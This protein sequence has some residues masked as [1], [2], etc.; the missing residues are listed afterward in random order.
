MPHKTQITELDKVLVM[1]IRGRER[2]RRRR[3][4]W[5]NLSICDRAYRVST[6]NKAHRIHSRRIMENLTTNNST[7]I[8]G[9]SSP[10]NNM[11]QSSRSVAKVEAPTFTNTYL[12]SHLGHRV[13]CIVGRL[14][15]FLRGFIFGFEDFFRW[16]AV[17]FLYWFNHEEPVLF[18]AM[19]SAP[20]FVESSPIVRQCYRNRLVR[21]DLLV[22]P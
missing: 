16:F 3:R 7:V 19:F 15:L 9:H 5:M 6:Q 11:I 8:V 12:R 21:S 17:L 20:W 4:Q 14:G 2:G 22:L 1:F 18:A 13:H 10:I